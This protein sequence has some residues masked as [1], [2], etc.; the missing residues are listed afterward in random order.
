MGFIWENRR[1]KQEANNRWAALK[2]QM[3][4]KDPRHATGWCVIREAGPLGLLPRWPDAAVRG[5]LVCCVWVSHCEQ[6]GDWSPAVEPRS[7][8]EPLTF[9]K[10]KQK[11][12]KKR[13][14][15]NKDEQLLAF[16]A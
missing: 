15:P 3:G 13:P 4:T 8:C 11:T 12:V 5:R 7:K 9:G 14:W 1:I 16:G 2:R 6:E 10:K